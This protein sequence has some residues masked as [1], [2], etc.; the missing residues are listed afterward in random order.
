LPEA[1]ERAN[2]RAPELVLAD[3][4]IRQVDA[5]RAGAG[6]LLPENPRINLEARPAVTG[7]SFIGDMGYAGSVAALFDLGGAPSARVK[8]VE[9]DVE[10]ASAIRNIDRIDARLRVFSAYLEAQ[11]AG[12][13]ASEARRGIELAER[14]LDAADKRI[15][16]GA[17]AE[18]ERA[19]AQ[20]ELARVRVQEQA[21]LR[22]REHGI[23]RLRD[24]LDLP[25][26]TELELVTAAERP[27]ELAPLATFLHSAEKNHP[28]MLVIQARTESL[29]ATRTRLSRELFPKL[30]L[31]AGV[32]AAPVSPIFGIL[33]ITGE[34]P[35]AQRNQ[36][37]RAVVA[38][39][40]E[41]EE[42]RLD[43]QRRRIFR[44]I[45]AA[46]DAHAHRLSEYSMLSDVALPAAERSFDLAEAGWKAG[47]FDWF[48]V[49][50]AARD[51]V[52]LRGARIEALA[53]LWN[54]RVVLARARGGDVP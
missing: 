19:S 40:L 36:G 42:T 10:L 26:S 21:A 35:F 47:R 8:E 49:A 27:P 51:L 15:A 50:L 45:R 41:T 20:V 28:D 5:R 37:A 3:L 6:I 25:E 43:L 12:L 24:G 39:E 44:D 54:A 9:R 46:W 33:G 34:L 11:L 48:R 32:D 29:L 2:Q 13:R 16:A 4:Q 23:M 1:L 7:G 18:F 17:G 30:G 52:E 53:A 14:V 38:R 31:I 22:E